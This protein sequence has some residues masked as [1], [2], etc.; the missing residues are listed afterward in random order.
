MLVVVGI[1]VAFLLP[2]APGY[3]G[4]VQVAFLVTLRP[5]GIAQELALGASVGYQLLM[6]L[7]VVVAGLAL[8][9]SSLVRR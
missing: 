7:P 1:V 8:L 3:A 5:L 9:R 6:V 2:N 4:S